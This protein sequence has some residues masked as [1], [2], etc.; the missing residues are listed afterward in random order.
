MPG[1]FQKAPTVPGK[2]A[3]IIIIGAGIAGVL[4]AIECAK[5]DGQIYLFEELDD[6]LQGTSQA[7]S[8]RLHTGLHYPDTD[9]I[10][11]VK[12]LHDTIRALR[13]LPSNCIRIQKSRYYLMSNSPFNQKHMIKTARLLQ[14]SYQALINEDAANAVLGEPENLIQFIEPKNYES[15][16]SAKIPF[17][18]ENNTEEQISVIFA[19][20]IVEPQIDIKQLR[21][22]LNQKL[23]ETRNI[24]LFTRHKVTSIQPR[25]DDFGY[26]VIAMTPNNKPHE[27]LSDAI[28][29]CSWQRME[30]LTPK[31]E[32]TNFRESIRNRMK[33]SVLVKLPESFISQNIPSSL[34]CYGPH[35]ALSILHDGTGVV[36][37]E[38]VT[39]L[40]SWMA[41]SKPDDP[42]IQSLLK[43]SVQHTDGI[44]KEI[45]EQIIDGFSKY[46]PSLKGAEPIELRIGFVRTPVTPQEQSSFSLY[47]KNSSIHARRASGI[48]LLIQFFGSC[49]VLNEARKFT[50]GPANAVSVRALIRSEVEHM[51]SWR[52]FIS[53]SPQNFDFAKFR[54]A[55]N[56][57]SYTLYKALGALPLD[58]Q[59][60]IFDCLNLMN[61]AQE[62]VR[63]QIKAMTDHFDDLRDQKREENNIKHLINEMSENGREPGVIPA[64]RAST[65]PPP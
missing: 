57:I 31:S 55:M 16:V 54:D 11:S 53:K 56:E 51:K 40:G 23:K 38:P 22:Y 50:Y 44:G 61:G 14:K 46:I 59:P 19:I 30:D 49:W 42:R 29:N 4:S 43:N 7:Q 32:E 10:T 28:I 20:D 5:D 15:Y 1:L 2:S 18:N 60:M 26:K 45:T 62:L 33:A 6:I 34:F 41:D 17:Q 39:N 24:H 35:A 63:H 12:C 52:G 21:A 8:Y 58:I 13:D 65:P 47:D 3:D 36:T 37:Y 64:D 48:E 27:I 9:F 25:N